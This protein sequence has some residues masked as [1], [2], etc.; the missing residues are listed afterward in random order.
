MGFL[1]LELWLG[2]SQGMGYFMEDQ[3]EQHFRY[4]ISVWACYNVLQKYNLQAYIII[5][6]VNS[7]MYASL[8][9]E[10][11]LLMDTV[12][13]SQQMVCATGQ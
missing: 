9:A 1:L 6:I 2:K 13:D 7:R 4:V 5:H 8:D 12:W 3:V 11:N 10:S